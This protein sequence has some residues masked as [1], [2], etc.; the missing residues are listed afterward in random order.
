MRKYFIWNVHF[1]GTFHWSSHSFSPIIH[2]AHYYGGGTRKRMGKCHLNKGHQEEEALRRETVMKQVSS[3]GDL[4]RTLSWAAQCGMAGTGPV[5]RG[6][7]V[8][9]AG[10][11]DALWNF[12]TDHALA[13]GHGIHKLWWTLVTIRSVSPHLGV[14]SHAAHSPPPSALCWM[15]SSP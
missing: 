15:D 14:L 12:R 6:R 8:H 3:S 13:G 2:L 5:G 4:C 1:F 7:L 11:A 10:K 9:S